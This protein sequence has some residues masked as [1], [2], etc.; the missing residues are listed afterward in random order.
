MKH[1][2]ESEIKNVSGGSLGGLIGK[3]IDRIGRVLTVREIGKMASDHFS[4]EHDKMV[5]DFKRDPSTV[6]NRFS[7]NGD[8]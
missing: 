3:G 1:L 5:A 6:T 4:R 8:F 7:F 2:S